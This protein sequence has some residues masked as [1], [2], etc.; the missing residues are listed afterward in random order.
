[1]ETEQDTGHSHQYE[2][3]NK[4]RLS[5]SGSDNRTR[6]MVSRASVGVCRGPK[7]A[8]LSASLEASDSEA[9]F[10]SQNTSVG[11]LAAAIGIGKD[12]QLRPVLMACGCGRTV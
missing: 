6:I 5:P 11:F 2:H 12:R 10:D 3:G 7:A 8:W 1:M 4:H 9:F